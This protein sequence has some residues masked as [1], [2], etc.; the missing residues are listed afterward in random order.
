MDGTG[1]ILFLGVLA[2]T[3]PVCCPSHAQFNW[4]SGKSAHYWAWPKQW[5][6]DLARQHA[7]CFTT[8]CQRCS[9][10]RLLAEV[11]DTSALSQ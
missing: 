7:P 5:G 11:E 4:K 1:P 2:V 8:A 10:K 3:C 6:H 9:V